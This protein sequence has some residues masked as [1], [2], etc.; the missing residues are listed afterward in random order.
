MLILARHIPA[1]ALQLMLAQRG[2]IKPGYYFQR[3]DKWRQIKKDVQDA[4]TKTGLFT[5]EEIKAPTYFLEFA[6]NVC[7]ADI[8]PS[9]AVSILLNTTTASAKEWVQ[10]AVV[11]RMN[12]KTSAD[13][14]EFVLSG[15]VVSFKERYMNSTVLNILRDKLSAL[16]ITTVTRPSIIELERHYAAFLEIKK[17]LMICDLKLTEEEMMDKLIKSLPTTIQL[18]IATKRKEL[19]TCE[20]IA[21]LTHDI[22]GVN[23]RSRYNSSH[24]TT[25]APTTLRR[26]KP[27]DNNY[28][29]TNYY[30]TPS[31]PQQY[32]S[33]YS[34]EYEQHPV[35]TPSS[36]PSWSSSTYMH[37]YEHP[38]DEEEIEYI[39]VNSL[40][41]DYQQYLI[42][43]EVI[44]SDTIINNNALTSRN[45][46][47]GDM[48]RVT[49]FHCGTV[50]HYAGDCD[51]N[52]GTMH[53]QTLAGKQAYL[54]FQRNTG[55]QA[56]YNPQQVKMKALERKRQRE[57]RTATGGSGNAKSYD[58]NRRPTSS[59]PLYNPSANSSNSNFNKKKVLLTPAAR[60][61]QEERN[62]SSG[63]TYR[64][65]TRTNNTNNANSNDRSKD[66]SISVDS[67]QQEQYPSVSAGVASTEKEDEYEDVVYDDT[68]DFNS[69]TLITT[70]Y[71]VTYEEEMNDED[72][73][74]MYEDK[75]AG[76]MCIPVELNGVKAGVALVD[77]GANKG[78]M[79]ASAI[80]ATG[81][82]DKVTITP[83]SNT[84][85]RGSTGELIPITGRFIANT[86]T[87]NNQFGHCC[88]Y[89]VDD[90]GK[91]D[92]MC[93]LVIGR[94]T[95]ATSKYPLLDNYSGKLYTADKSSYIQCAD[96]ITVKGANGK[97]RIRPKS[98]TRR[99][100]S[101]Q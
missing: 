58:A 29:Y 40:P 48:A 13:G 23:D 65:N 14:D 42:D 54:T 71:A 56:V 31:P 94:S 33:N 22:G 25:P 45:Q 93:D 10:D 35:H 70:S 101:S 41:I 30:D 34:S 63:A 20:E 52:D 72:T 44:S 37:S 96:G 36:S 18:L 8:S 12:A 9:D 77:S 67:L 4:I 81:L 92:I 86:T 78:L 98:P 53:T 28:Y 83:V 99:L 80:E 39:D 49:C 2:D 97:P 73:I 21:S 88:Y 19:K 7:K 62:R 89:I 57:Q 64:P 3:D 79:R 61:L 90:T 69:T 100:A 68:I 87:D 51:K 17:N 1:V 60:K 59:R 91:A 50:G 26:S 75:C 5:G 24:A 38:V 74:A 11:K 16:S 15:L 46:R 84:Y 32:Y 66:T 47:F 85:M 55:T 43:T 82:K 6:I 95:L 27:V 76:S